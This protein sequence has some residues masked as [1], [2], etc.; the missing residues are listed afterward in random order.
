[1]AETIPNKIWEKR[2]SGTQRAQFFPLMEEPKIDTLKRK[3]VVGVAPVG[4]FVT[5]DVLPMVP[6]NPKEVIAAAKECFDAGASLI[7][8]HCKT[9]EG[10]LSVDPQLSV[11]TL[12][13]IK[14]L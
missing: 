2:D 9:P 14:E 3:L 8:I 6:N 4:A 13:P 7:H 5:K 1:M 12:Q 10:I 11:D